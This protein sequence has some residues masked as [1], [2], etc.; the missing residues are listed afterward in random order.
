MRLGK[1]TLRDVAATSPRELGL[2]RNVGQTT[3]LELRSWLQAYGLI[4]GELPPDSSLVT[5]GAYAGMTLLDY[6]A[7]QA[8]Q[9]LLAKHPECTD[10]HIAQ[11]A[12]MLADAMI[13]EK[14]RRESGK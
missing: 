8:M 10:E 2:E 5:G 7:G 11:C 6:F 3:I 1:K 13:A 14:R 12:Y 9:I 4:L